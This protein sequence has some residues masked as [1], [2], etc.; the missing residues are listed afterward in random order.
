MGKKM[1]ST[2]FFRVFGWRVRR[3]GQQ[4]NNEDK[5]DY[6]MVYGG[7][8]DVTILTEPPSDPPGSKGPRLIF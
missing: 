5:W 2:T 8:G 3:L 7:C 1:E 6:D 4:V